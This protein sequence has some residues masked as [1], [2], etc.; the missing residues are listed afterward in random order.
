MVKWSFELNKRSNPCLILAIDYVHLNCIGNQNSTFGCV[1]II[2]FNPSCVCNVFLMLRQHT[3]K[4]CGLFNLFSIN[5]STTSVIPLNETWTK[6]EQNSC[7]LF[8]L[9]C[10]PLTSFD[11]VFGVWNL[12]T[13]SLSVACPSDGTVRPRHGCLVASSGNWAD[14]HTAAIPT[15]RRIMWCLSSPGRCVYPNAMVVVI[16]C[17]LYGFIEQFLQL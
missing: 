16:T 8:C 2:V 13:N 12:W 15:E 1:L 9:L 14:V 11:P 3:N 6:L 5:Y 7:Q 10:I 17:N 4:Y